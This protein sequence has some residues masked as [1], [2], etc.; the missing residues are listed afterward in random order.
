MARRELC[1]AGDPLQLL[2]DL[3]KMLPPQGGEVG[4]AEAVGGGRGACVAQLVVDPAQGGR[5]ISNSRRLYQL[6]E[7]RLGI[8]QQDR[9]GRF[10]HE[11]LRLELL[12]HAEAGIHAGVQGAL[13]QKSGAESI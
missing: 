10:P 8:S 7:P 13:P 11:A 5:E 1:P 6:L 9:V 4:W 12:E 2:E 3:V